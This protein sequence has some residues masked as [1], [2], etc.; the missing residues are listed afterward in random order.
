MVTAP[1]GLA[2]T[3]PSY[4]VQL[5]AGQL[6]VD[7]DIGLAAASALPFDLAL[8]KSVSGT[9]VTGGT[10]TWVITVSNNSVTPAPATLTVADSLPPGLSFVSAIGT[11]WVCS[12]I[13]Q[14]LTCTGGGPLDLGERAQIDVVTT[15]LATAGTEVRN[16]ASVSAVGPELSLANNTD[17]ASVLVNRSITTTVTT[18]TTTTPPPSAVVSVPSGTPSTTVVIGRTTSLPSTGADIG[19]RLR[20]V[21]LLIAAGAFAVVLGRRKASLEPPR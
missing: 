5:V 17:D 6:V 3:V 14:D 4:E 1:A 18:T 11:G 13:G 12:I 2:A 9:V 21:F 19:G 15:V 16:V 10:A 7:A 8:D 20:I